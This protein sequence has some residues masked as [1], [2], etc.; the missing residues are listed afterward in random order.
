MAVMVVT[1]GGVDDVTGQ[2]IAVASP[3]ESTVAIVT[4]L[5]CQATCEVISWVT[6]ELLK[7][8]IAIYCAVSPSL[9]TV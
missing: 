4:S 1:Q 2:A 3:D 8:P 7:V 6:G 5:D 9:D